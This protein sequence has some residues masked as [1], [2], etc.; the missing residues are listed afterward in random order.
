LDQSPA[1][2]LTRDFVAKYGNDEGLCS[3]LSCHFHSRSW[4]GPA[5]DF[6]RSL[7]EAAREWLDG[8]RHR[9]VVRWVENYIDELSRDIQRAEIQE[10][11]GLD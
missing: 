7:R 9:N 8:E 5:S 1:G 4:M 6:Y 3:L 10:E 2:R 11:R